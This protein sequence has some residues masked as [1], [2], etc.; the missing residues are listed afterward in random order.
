MAAARSCGAAASTLGRFV[1]RAF[2]DPGSDSFA[3]SGFETISGIP[4]GYPEL[5]DL[6]ISRI[7]TERSRHVSLGTRWRQS[8]WMLVALFCTANGDRGLTHST[9][10]FLGW[11]MNPRYHF[12]LEVLRCE[13]DF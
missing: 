13:R 5:I 8:D 4:Y 3:D 1:S 9:T 7:A 12:P 11:S 2:G 10:S 6:Y